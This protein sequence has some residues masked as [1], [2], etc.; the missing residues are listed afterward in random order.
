[1][2]LGVCSV[3]FTLDTLLFQFLSFSCV[4]PADHLWTILF[5]LLGVAE[6]KTG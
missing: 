4:V 2:A 5:Y 1:M 3:F 6:H